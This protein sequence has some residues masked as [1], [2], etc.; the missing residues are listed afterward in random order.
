MPEEDHQ[1]TPLHKEPQVVEGSVNFKGKAKLGSDD[2]PDKE[3]FEGSEIMIAVPQV[4]ED[5]KVVL[6][7]VGQAKVMKGVKLAADE[8]HLGG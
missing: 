5:G 4:L 1:P 3:K 2:E 8:L 7:I 6:V